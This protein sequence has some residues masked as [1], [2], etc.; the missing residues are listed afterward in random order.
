MQK[1]MCTWMNELVACLYGF[2]FTFFDQHSELF[3][4]RGRSRVTHGT[5]STNL[6]CSHV[7]PFFPS[8]LLL[9]FCSDVM[10]IK[11]IQSLRINENKIFFFDLPMEHS[12][13]SIFNTYRSFTDTASCMYYFIIITFFQCSLILY[14]SHLSLYS[15]KWRSLQSNSASDRGRR[16][17][18]L[19]IL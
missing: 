15:N 16:A 4:G 7:D 8:I 1:T 3:V 9:I 14:F 2:F 12:I 10:Y 13:I 11:Q 18:P 6:R 19:Q 5:N 17:L